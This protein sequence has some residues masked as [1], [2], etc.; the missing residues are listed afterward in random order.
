MKNSWKHI[1]TILKYV[2]NSSPGWTVLN[3][4]LV[5]IRGVL[6][7]LLLY[8]V[9]L[10]VDEI[11]TIAALPLDERDFSLL[12]TVLIA[13]GVIFLINAL[14]ASLGLLVRER[15]SY[16]ISDFF[17][18]L[19][20]DK[21]TSL[22]YGYFEHPEYQSIFYRALNEA[23]FRPSRIFYG[24]LGVIQNFIT[25]LV[26]GGVL[27]MVHWSVS[28]ILL[29]ITLP[30]S[31]IRLRHARDLFRFKKDNTLLE[32]EVNYYNRLITAPEFAKEVRAFDLS[33]L[34]RRRFFNR[35][36]KWRQT[37]F[38]MLVNKTR[39]EIVVQLLAAT[40]FFLVYGLIAWKA[41][42]GQISIGEVVL[43]F[44]AMQRGYAYLQEFLGRSS[45]LYQD[46]L[47]LDNL[48]EFIDLREESKAVESKASLS[49]PSPIQSGIEFRNTGFHYP[50]NNRWIL[51][52][53]NLKIL[54]GET[55][56]LVGANGTG[57]STIVKLL[58]SLYQP[59]E[60][61]ILV[62]D[63]PLSKIVDSQRVA[64]ISVIFQDFILYN[65][66]A[67]EN[68]WFGDAQKPADDDLI[69]QAANRA[70]INNVIE[71]FEK[72][73]NTTLGTVFEGSEQM[74]PGQWQ[75]LALARSFYNNSQ[76]IILDEPTSSLD[77]FSEAKLLKY[78]RSVT[79]NRTALI[80][81]HRLSTIRMADRVIV[82]EGEQ[83]TETG[84]YEELMSKNGS[85]KKMVDALSD[86]FI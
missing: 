79:E 19:I 44:L 52:N 75:R 46:S 59:V 39:R 42:D 18:N 74:S 26:M 15:Q 78:I 49:F 69:K 86:S 65:V 6:P 85:F 77:A 84:S 71:G 2:W 24:V 60:G 57:K 29:L 20:H 54:P 38:S 8:L 47:F 10:L 17:D 50:S 51:R 13:A 3:I 9:K 56:A 53:L 55:I 58:C 68:I 33:G 83:V 80:I 62:D 73:Y 48:F 63:I 12:L 34:F 61:E 67:R 41:F 43:Y 1:R 81:S 40:C 5:L 25:I 35:K 45:S 7:L 64:N 21:T 23:S 70:G 36:R 14:T 27:L 4:L 37:Q 16:V 31:W 82:L 66:T 32:R 22:E 30:V 28:V 76:L 72:G 11:Q